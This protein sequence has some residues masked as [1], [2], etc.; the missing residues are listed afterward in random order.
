MTR[1]MFKVIGAEWCEVEITLRDR[2][3]GLE[4]SI[5]GTAGEVVPEEE[6]QRMAVDYWA[7]FFEDSPEEMLRFAKEY[8][9]FDEEAAARKV[10][11]IDGEYHGLDVRKEEDGKVYLVHSCGQI[12]EEMARFFPEVEPYFEWH[13]NGMN[14]GCKHQ[15]EL[16]WGHGY[17]VALSPDE[18]TDAQRTT[19][20]NL[21]EGKAN[22]LRAKLILDTP[23]TA[24]GLIDLLGRTV[25]VHEARAWEGGH[26]RGD[27]M[28]EVKEAAR[29]K[30]PTVLFAGA[31]YKD[32]L[33][34]PCPECG[35]RYGTQ[36]LF[37]PLP[38][39][40]VEWAKGGPA[41]GPAS[42]MV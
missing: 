39:E 24:N 13:L 27:L 4:L 6:A 29:R 38:D 36:W 23:R 2:G 7:G 30:V 3:Q 35:Y 22:K 19:L 15:R 9:V 32:S 37:E 5:C 25:T 40:V 18:L 31:V 33:G 14:A 21:A 16:G 26:A 1:K 28:G 42:G 34:A 12:R 17:T 41:S 20:D 10:L 11:E 8:R